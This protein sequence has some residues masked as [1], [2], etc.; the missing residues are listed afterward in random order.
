MLS[1]LTYLLIDCETDSVHDDA[2][3]ETSQSLPRSGND[4]AR[5]RRP[6]RHALFQNMLSRSRSTKQ[7]GS[8]SKQPSKTKTSNK[9]RII[10][11]RSR[12]RREATTQEAPQTAPLSPDRGFRD[13]VETS[14][15]RNRSADRPTNASAEQDDRTHSSG[16]LQAFVSNSSR[17]AGDFSTKI[18]KGIAKISNRNVH[19]N[20]REDPP[21]DYVFRIINLPLV[22]QVRETRLRRSLAESKDKTEFWLPAL[23]Y[24]CIE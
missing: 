2:V 24:R 3:S 8:G 21:S 19:A 15:M 7:D 1:R 18:G 16:R 10:N 17:A 13:A 22:D 20:E 14:Q 23:P 4:H 11:S 5:D 12:E 9:E 6:S